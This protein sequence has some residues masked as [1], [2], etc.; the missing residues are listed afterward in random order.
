MYYLN[1]MVH[2]GMTAH[3]TSSDREGFYVMYTRCNGWDWCWYVVELHWRGWESQEFVWR[4]GTDCE[5]GDSNTD[6]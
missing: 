4:R 1:D 2:N 3:F 5:D 6:W